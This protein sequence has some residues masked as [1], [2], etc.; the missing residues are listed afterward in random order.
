MSRGLVSENA[1]DRLGWAEPSRYDQRGG[2]RSFAGGVAVEL[3][4]PAVRTVD[5]SISAFWI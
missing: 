1:G 4:A 2:R 3:V 5:S